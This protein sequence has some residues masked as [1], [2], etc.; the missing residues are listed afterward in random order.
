MQ[1]LF[2]GVAVDGIF[3]GVMTAAALALSHNKV[4]KI[5]IFS[6]LQ[7]QLRHQL[8]IFLHDDFVCWQSPH[9]QQEEDRENQD[10]KVDWA[11]KKKAKSVAEANA[12]LVLERI[13]A[14]APLQQQEKVTQ[15][16]WHSQCLKSLFL[17]PINK[18][19]TQL[20]EIAQDENNINL[21]NP[22]WE[23]WI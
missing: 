23:P 13:K 21:M 2:N 17:I 11:H 18:K 22:T 3:N 6:R 8:T 15:L 19:I 4:L 10:K 16:L 14:L 1:H 5:S 12:S 20:I 7:D 9:L